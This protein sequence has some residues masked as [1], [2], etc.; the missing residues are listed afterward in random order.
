MA[1]FDPFV[2]A[3]VEVAGAVGADAV[4]HVFFVVAAGHHDALVVVKEIVG[5]GHD[6]G[7]I[8]VAVAVH[9][10]FAYDIGSGDDGALV[11]ALDQAGADREDDDAVIGA[12]GADPGVGRGGPEFLLPALAAFL[13]GGGGSLC[14]R[15]SCCFCFF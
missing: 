9:N 5:V 2:T 13:Q 4:R 1:V 7:H 12:D 14:S 11:L 15:G 8:D 10:V 6:A 3:L